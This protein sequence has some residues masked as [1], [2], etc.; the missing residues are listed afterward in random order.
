MK[1]TP[2]LLCADVAKQELVVFDGKTVWTVP[3][4]KRAIAALLKNREGFTIVCEP[5]N[6]F[7]LELVRMAREK[8]CRVCLVNPQDVKNYRECRSFRAKTDRK[9]AEAIYEF[10]L[11]HFEVLREWA[12]PAADLERLHQLM[13]RRN[14]LVSSRTKLR[15]VFGDS[16]EFDAVE[17]EIGRLIQELEVR[18]HELASTYE[19][20]KLMLS[21]PG[22]GESIAPALVYLLNRYEFKDANALVAFVGLDLRVRD[23]GRFKGKRKLS[24]RGD[25]M[26][27]YLVVLA[28]YS[29]LHSKVA[30][31]AN[32][33]LIAENRHRNER[34][35]MGARK[36]LKAAFALHKRKTPFDSQKWVW[37][38]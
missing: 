1:D 8:G 12:P 28:G 6:S 9:D 17:E 5:T 29:L 20:Y 21:L 3:N 13:A 19:D 22:V 23:S 18:T 2:D 25:S 37:K 32:A 4:Q 14:S 11:R 35:A 38:T 26:L 24:K 7:H 30:R 31:D 33:K 15:M 36:L 16:P 34:A 10:A 27:R